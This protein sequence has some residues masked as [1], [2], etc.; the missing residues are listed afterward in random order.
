VNTIFP[1]AYDDLSEDKKYLLSEIRKKERK[2]IQSSTN[3]G[4]MVLL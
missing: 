4:F 1:D 2:E 3:I